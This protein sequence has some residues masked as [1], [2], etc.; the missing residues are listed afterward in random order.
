MHLV[1]C[2]VLA[3][4]SAAALSLV[5]CH[6]QAPVH[7]DAG[8]ALPARVEPGDLVASTTGLTFHSAFWINLHHVLY[9]E[10]WARRQGTGGRSLAGSFPEPLVATLSADERAAWDAAVAYYD[11]ALAGRDL[12][13]DA[14]LAG[15]RRALLAGSSDAPR[16]GLASDHRAALAAAAPVYRAHWWP[17]HDRANRAWIA[18]AAERVRTLSPE[19]PERLARLYAAPWITAARVDVVYVASW[20]GA[21]SDSDPDLQLVIASSAAHNQGWAAA[22]IVFHEVSHALV[23]PVVQVRFTDEAR[24]AAKHLPLLWHAALFY[25]TGEVTRQ[26]LAARGVDYTPYLY[27]NGLFERGWSRFR[28][29]LETFWRPYIDGRV[30]LAEAVRQ[31]VAAAPAEP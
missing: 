3:I 10:A 20:Q 11:R 31:V 4:V 24:A 19:V 21:Y 27:A 14:G 22:E 1:L 12:V 7:A 26:A 8:A 9:A 6:A 15:I 29:P 18:G 28:Q 17:A 2:R 25:L 5:S 30:P 16:A 13:F 23:E